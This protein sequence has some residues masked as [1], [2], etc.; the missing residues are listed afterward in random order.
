[1]TPDMRVIDRIAQVLA[2][3]GALGTFAT[4]RTASANELRLDVVGVGP[5]PLPLSPANARAC[6]ASR[7]PPGMACEIR[8][9]STGT[10]AMPGRSASAK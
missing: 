9:C 7:A 8:R 4:R 10:C 2:S 3:T 1:V 6:A 5:I